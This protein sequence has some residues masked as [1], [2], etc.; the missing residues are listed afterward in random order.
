[1]APRR[2]R[3]AGP[4]LALFLVGMLL[5]G[6]IGAVIGSFSPPTYGAA[7][8]LQLSP[9]TLPALA[10]LQ[11]AQQTEQELTQYTSGELAF[12]SGEGLKRALEERLGTAPVDFAAV[13]DAQSSVVRLSATSTSQE[14]A[15]RIVRTAVELYS[16]RRV[17]QDAER[18][19][20]ALAA[21][22]RALAEATGPA[23]PRDTGAAA[24]IERLQNL[25]LDV[26]LQSGE[27]AVDI[28]E[29]PAA[30]AQ[31]GS[32][33]WVLP[34]ALGA[35]LGGLVAV[36]AVLLRR[37]LSSR[38]QSV[39][40][41][42]PVVDRVLQPEVRL[43]SPG[44]RRTADQEDADLRTARLLV[45]QIFG[46]QPTIGRIVVAAG[47]SARSGTS[48]V[49]SLVAAGAADHGSTIL[50]RLRPPR[51][52]DPQ[53]GAEAP[54]TRQ[55]PDGSEV[56]GERSDPLQIVDLPPDR[57]RLEIGGQRFREILAATGRA[58]PCVVVD[59]GVI[60]DSPDLL[61]TL[62]H[63]T[64]V[65][66]VLRL[67]ADTLSDAAGVVASAGSG[68]GRLSAALTRLPWFAGVAHASLST[69]RSRS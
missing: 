60:T 21:V 22:D 1:M 12:L 68:A 36:L 66:L 19:A 15:I 16:E 56:T 11:G 14:E 30:A 63:A 34:T 65:V 24:R 40:D 52:P 49:A 54:Q 5:G 37:A 67:G 10:S 42:Q 45:A 59:G 38:V 39:D 48:T 35:V 53:P 6:S 25:R 23:A 55:L 2:T 29:E 13:E 44:S 28:I 18:T 31:E 9:V 7:S 4:L 51:Q 43:R 61:R 3:S 69:E 57:P 41:V 17:A 26:V 58:N 64:D 33:P 47:V 50:L 27:G 20:G 62:S 46:G 8:L 32:A